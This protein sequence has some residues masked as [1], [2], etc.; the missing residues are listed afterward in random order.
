MTLGE[1]EATVLDHWLRCHRSTVSKWSAGDLERQAAAVAQLADAELQALERIG[2][3]RL[4]AW[5][6]VRN[7]MVLKAPPE[8]ST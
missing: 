4:I 1:I 3:D 6:D 5:P 2:V 7:Q 8:I